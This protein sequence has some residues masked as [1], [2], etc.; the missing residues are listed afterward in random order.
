MFVTV[1][2]FW[3]EPKIRVHRDAYGAR[4]DMSGATISL[5]M[6]ELHGLVN[7]GADVLDQWYVEQEQADGRV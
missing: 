1:T 3:E 4:I 7:A 2:R 5:S 6:Q